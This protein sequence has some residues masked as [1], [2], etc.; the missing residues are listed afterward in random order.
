MII[1]CCHLIVKT[2]DNISFTS[3]CSLPYIIYLLYLVC[4]YFKL[5]PFYMCYT[6]PDSFCRYGKLCIVCLSCQGL[7]DC[8]MLHGQSHRCQVS[9]TML[10][11]VLPG[12][13]MNGRLE[14]SI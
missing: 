7:A 9:L 8:Q 1:Q 13:S 2:M 14:Y 6:R 12:L 4:N 5:M 3:V 10:P 11:M